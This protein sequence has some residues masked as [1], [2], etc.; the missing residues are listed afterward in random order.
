MPQFNLTKAE[1]TLARVSKPGQDQLKLLS[2]LDDAGAAYH[3][4]GCYAEAESCYAKALTL[5]NAHGLIDESYLNTLHRLGI[6]YRIEKKYNEA[7]QTHLQAIN[8]AKAL[9]GPSSIKVAEQSNYLAG[10]YHNWGRG[11][12]ALKIMHRSLVLFREVEGSD[13]I[14]VGMC[15]FALA[16][17]HNHLDNKE[18]AEAE[19]KKA[20]Q[21]MSVQLSGKE[22]TIAQGLLGMAMFHFRQRDIESA[23]T[24]FRHSFVLQ[25]EALWPFHPLVPKTLLKLG[26]FYESQN[27]LA[28]AEQCYQAALR[29][30]Q[31]AF[32][33]EN[34]ILL[35]TLTRLAKFHAKHGEEQK[36]K[37]YGRL[38]LELDDE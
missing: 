26:D 12:E 11:D 25:E 29:K 16:L 1:A 5:K 7:E 23:E 34:P 32:G 38:I 22:E 19:Y 18:M 31:V 9:Y 14:N 24:L 2:D 13:S 8:V 37:E 6:I 35:D 4:Y 28:K 15:H 3:A 20:H 33:N 30:Q 21:I 36:A 17:I 27:L 10:M